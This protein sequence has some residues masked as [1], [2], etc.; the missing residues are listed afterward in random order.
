MWREVQETT[1]LRGA[2]EA[3]YQAN[4]TSLSQNT[5][6]KAACNGITTWVKS[7]LSIDAL[8]Q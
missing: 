4:C 2:L 1:Q 3:F 6:A 7:L 5:Q 8:K